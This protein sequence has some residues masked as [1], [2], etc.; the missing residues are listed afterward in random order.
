MPAGFFLDYTLEGGR[1][2]TVTM[3]QPPPQASIVLAPVG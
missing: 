1:V 3:E 2:K